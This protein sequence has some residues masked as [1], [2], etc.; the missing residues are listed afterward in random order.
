MVFKTSIRLRH[1][2]WWWRQLRHAAQGGHLMLLRLL[3]VWYSQWDLTH[4]I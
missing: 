1:P 2:V 4:I 3:D